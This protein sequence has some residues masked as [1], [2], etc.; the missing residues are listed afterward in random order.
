[1]APTGP[2]SESPAP[3]PFARIQMLESRVNVLETENKN[4]AASIV[5]LEARVIP[6]VVEK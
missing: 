3:S 1:M 6:P 5:A 2:I 4:M